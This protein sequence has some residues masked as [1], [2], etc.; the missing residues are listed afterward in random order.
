MDSKLLDRFAYPLAEVIQHMAAA[1]CH[2]LWIMLMLNVCPL[3]GG[4]GR[5]VGL[6]A[7]MICRWA[8]GGCAVFPEDVDFSAVFNIFAHSAV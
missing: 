6:L 7:P 5:E 8:A 3:M 1:T 4:N 2:G